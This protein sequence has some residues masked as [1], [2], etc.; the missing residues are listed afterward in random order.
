MKPVTEHG[1][2]VRITGEAGEGAGMQAE[3]MPRSGLRVL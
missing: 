1:A 2:K 3:G